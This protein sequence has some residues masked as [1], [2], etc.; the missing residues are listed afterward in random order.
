M[1]ALVVGAS[2]LL[3]ASPSLAEQKAP[4]GFG[5]IKF[6][7]TKEEAWKAIDGKGEWKDDNTFVH[8]EGLP[9]FLKDYE[10]TVRIYK[11][12]INDIVI[13]RN[14]K[15]VLEVFC[16]GDILRILHKIEQKYEISPVS[17]QRDRIIP[18]PSTIFYFLYSFSDGSRIHIF[19]SVE[20]SYIPDRESAPDPA[21]QC[22]VRIQ[23]S[24]PSEDYNPF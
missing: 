5:P 6:G 18:K 4:D 22:W 13:A 10:V 16:M 8:K 12:S 9:D 17:Y 7:M 2:I 11:D 1:R 20:K 21:R 14:S 24:P 23:Y 3:W 15:G 19:A